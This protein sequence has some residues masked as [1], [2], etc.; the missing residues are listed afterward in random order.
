MQFHTLQ[1]LEKNTKQHDCLNYIKPGAKT[2]RKCN[3]KC[4]YISASSPTLELLTPY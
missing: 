3:E 1:H 4:E 2:D